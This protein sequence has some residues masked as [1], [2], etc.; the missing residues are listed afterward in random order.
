MAVSVEVYEYQ[1]DGGPFVGRVVHDDAVTGPAPGILIAPTFWGL[2]DL[3]VDKA[4]RLAE[5]G[6]VVLVADPYGGGRTGA[7]AE[8]ATALMGELMADR[9]AA[10]ARFQNALAVLKALPGVDGSRTAALGYC[11]GG[12]C[13]LDLARSG[14]EV[15]GVAPFHAIFDAPAHP[16]APIKAKLLISQGWDDPLTPPDSFVALAKE[17]TEAGADWQLHAYGHTGHSFT[18]PGKGLGPGFGYSESAD[19]R[20][21][22]ALTA[23]LNEI[24][25]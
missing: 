17:L 2:R 4:R 12:K 9:K 23:F 6:Y 11:M 24:F 13:V 25:A 3:E 1:G 15:T 22:A 5:A 19:R 20:S 16:N 14:A 18:T 10:Q 21:W 8:E 7:T